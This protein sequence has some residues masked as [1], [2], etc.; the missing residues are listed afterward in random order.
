MRNFVELRP[1][2]DLPS[3]SVA[4]FFTYCVFD[5]ST[6]C[7]RETGFIHFCEA[8]FFLDRTL[9][10]TTHYRN[11]IR[12]CLLTRY[13]FGWVLLCIAWRLV[14]GTVL[15]PVQIGLK[16]IWVFIT[17]AIIAYPATWVVQDIYLKTLSES[18]SCNDYNRYYQSLPG[19]NWGIFLGVIYFLMIIHGIFI[20]SLAV[21][22]DSGLVPENLRFNRCRS[23][24]IS[25]L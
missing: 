11:T 22:F 6:C 8:D 3:E 5:F 1:P 14:P 17:A 23:F 16:G 19:K 10:S 24:T 12:N 9:C 20:Y 18:D 4:S 13:D 7:A 21:V 2:R 25:T 15:M